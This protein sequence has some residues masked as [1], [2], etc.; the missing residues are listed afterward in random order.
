[1][2]FLLK[3][4]YPGAFYHIASRGNERSVHFFQGRYKA[5]LSNK[6]VDHNL[7]ALKELSRKPS[8]G[9]ITEKVET[10]FGKNRVLA[11]G[12]KIYLCDRHTGKMF[13]GIGQHF[14]I[15]AS[16]VWQASRRI[17]MK[18]SQDTVK[19]EDLTPM[20]LFGENPC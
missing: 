7:P 10:V 4:A 12:V 19:N 5:I 14:D 6:K 8:I 13:K 16:G 9:E 20:T 1:M 17:A 15:G 2:A 18:I 11:R 3:I